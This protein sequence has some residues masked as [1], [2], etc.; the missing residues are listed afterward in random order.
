[1][2]LS[3]LLSALRALPEYQSAVHALTQRPRPNLALN[4]PRAARLP[5][6]AALAE[7]W[8]LGGAIAAP[9]LVLAARAERA[10]TL[11]E[12]LNAWVLHQTVLPFSEPNPLFY[13]L[14]LW[15]PRTIRARI[16]VLQ[17]LVAGGGKPTPVIVASA[18]ALMTRTLPKQEFIAE[19]HT[20][21]VGDTVHLE[22]LLDNWVGIGYTSETTVIEAGQFARRGGIVDIYPLA[23]DLPTRIELFGDEIET[24]RHFEPATQ[25][26][27]EAAAS[28]TITP[29][30]EALP[31]FR[32]KERYAGRRE[33]L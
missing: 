9:V 33:D 23:D 13:E 2:K 18:R 24:L 31:K 28:V 12:E 19:T 1:M 29:A 8:T 30:R 25:R 20:L 4:L 11:V 17:A 16:S 6:I 22:Q 14:S 3:G 32:E 27:G 15:G 5:V 21:K 10:A 7:D 26:S